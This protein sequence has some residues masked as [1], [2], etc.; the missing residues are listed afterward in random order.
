MPRKPGADLAR[1]PVRLWRSV[2]EAAAI[3]RRT[4]ASVALGFG[5]YVS[6]PIY[7]AARRLGVP[8]VI[9]EQNALPGLANKVAAR[10]TDH[11]YTSFPGTPLPHAHCIGLP[12]RRAI[13]ELD[14]SSRRGPARARFGLAPDLPTLLVSGGSQ[15]ALRINTAVV[16]ARD[17][18]LSR[19]IQVLHVLGPRNVDDSFVPVADPE[20]GAVYA[21]L[22]YVEAMEDA[23]SAA[24][25]MLGRCGAST[26][27]ETA[28]VGLPAVYVP[29]PH[30][31]GEQARNATLVVAAGGGELL[32]DAECTSDW[33]SRRIPELVL[34]AGRLAAMSAASR[35]V[36]I[37]DAAA[38]LATATLEVAR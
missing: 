33:V 24:D 15:G 36:G 2:A 18:L 27:L 5:G 8:V 28:A 9:H 30:G 31:N 12:L 10:L 22:G 20:T 11:V 21:P 35:G 38:A 23:Y 6:T 7:L 19:G 34:D 25:L 13:T 3:L 14:R 26:V 29:Y 17:H 4:Q 37:T 32:P 1:V 16:G